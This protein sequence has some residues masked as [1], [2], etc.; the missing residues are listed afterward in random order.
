MK[1]IASRIANEPKVSRSFRLTII[2][3]GAN[4]VIVAKAFD[5]NIREYKVPSVDK[6]KI[7]DSN[8]AADA[9]A[10]GFLSQWIQNKSLDTCIQ[11]AIYCAGESLKQLGAMLPSYPPRFVE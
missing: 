8:A 1:E 4:E 7:V 11:G 9:F 6:E 2:T 3:Q 10:G 5:T